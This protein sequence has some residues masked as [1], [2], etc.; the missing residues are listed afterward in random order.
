MSAPLR[1]RVCP[2]LRRAT[3][4][5]ALLFAGAASGAAP[6]PASQLQAK[7]RAHIESQLPQSGVTGSA[8]ASR[9]DVGPIDART[10]SQTCTQLDILLPPPDRLR[11]KLQVGLRCDAPQ[12]WA[13]W[14]PATVVTSV[15]YWVAARTL[16]AGTVIEA[17]DLIQKSGDEAA[18]PR[19]AVQNLDEAIG[20]ILMS[21]MAPGAPL[22]LHSLRQQVAVQAGQTVKLLVDGGNFQITSDG[23]ALNQA[24]QGQVA[25]VRTA[26]GAVVRGI[27]G[28]GGVVRVQY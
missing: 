11:G 19:G 25:Q 16:P 5:V 8:A 2:P 27:A 9:I 13:A 23:R 28:A 4:M 24:L 6:D 21:R 18:L 20:R 26:S 12:Q 10:A 7:I 17:A 3:M 1:H 15:S 14:V 22:N